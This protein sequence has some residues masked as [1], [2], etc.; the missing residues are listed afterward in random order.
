MSLEPFLTFEDILLTLNKS[1]YT[2]LEEDQLLYLQTM[3]T[4]AIIAYC[5][6]DP[7]T[8]PEQ[9]TAVLGI[10]A[11]R[12]IMLWWQEISNN[13]TGIAKQSFAEMSIEF[14]VNPGFDP[15]TK[16]ILDRYRSLTIA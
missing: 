14:N 15:M 10:V 2:S 3:S 16:Q 11:A 13:T 8:D 4:A 9:N 1:D 6:Q 7:R 5:G 12:M